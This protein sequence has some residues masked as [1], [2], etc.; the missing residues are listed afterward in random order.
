MAG[1]GGDLIVKR[2][3]LIGLFWHPLGGRGLKLGSGLFNSRGAR[4]AGQQQFLCE[5]FVVSL[6]AHSVDPAWGHP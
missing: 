5:M 6:P 3:L 2:D 4:M 1:G